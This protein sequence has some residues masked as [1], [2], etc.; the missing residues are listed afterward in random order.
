MDV[1]SLLSKL[2][3]SFDVSLPGGMTLSPSLLEAGVILFLLF[4]LVLMIAQLRMRLVHWHMK[5]IYPGIG[6]GFI[7]ALTIEGLLL[8]GGRTIL[9]EVLGWKDAPKPISNVLD[10]SREKLVDV[11]GVDAT[12]PEL[13]AFEFT[14]QSAVEV[15]GALSQ[16]DKTE[17]QSIICKPSD[18]LEAE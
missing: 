6:I 9:T 18:I 16:T 8:V 2:Q 10:T 12:V 15:F 4:I 17:V 11:L 5:G 13:K 14:P 1:S 7:I 3:T